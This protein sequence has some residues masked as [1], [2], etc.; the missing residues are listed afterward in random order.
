MLDARRN[1]T[2]CPSRDLHPELFENNLPAPSLDGIFTFIGERS[3]DM[4]DLGKVSEETKG[5]KGVLP[6]E[7]SGFPQFPL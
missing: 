2:A 6:V 3:I 4:I 1:A 5:I 7:P